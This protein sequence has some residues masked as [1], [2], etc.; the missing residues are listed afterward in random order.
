ELCG[1]T[2]VRKTGD[3]GQFILRSEGAVAAGVRRIEAISATAADHYIK[4]ELKQLNDARELLKSK[5]VI[6]TLSEL[7]SKNNRLE[8]EIEELLHDKAIRLKNE[9]KNSVQKINGVHFVSARIDLPTAALKDVSFQLRN[10]LDNLFAVFGSVNAG[11]PNLTCV[12]SDSLVADKNMNASVIIR[13]LAT[14]IKGGGGGQA[15]FATAGGTEMNGLDKA[16]ALAK[17]M[18]PKE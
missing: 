2:H 6:K 9:I 4:S 17:N 14:E 10:E 18:I 5:D 1:G 12:I 3:I 11:K 15:F 16:L 13:N 8:K 7:L